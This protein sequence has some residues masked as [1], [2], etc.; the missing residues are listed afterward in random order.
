VIDSN[1]TSEDACYWFL[2]TLAFQKERKR[3]RKRK[4]PR[5]ERER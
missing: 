5:K 4:R 2:E 1:Q 3:S